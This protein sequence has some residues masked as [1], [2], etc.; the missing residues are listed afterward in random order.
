M[1]GSIFSLNA[2]PH[3]FL[4]SP[5]AAF[6]VIVSL[7]LNSLFVSLSNKEEEE[8]EKEEDFVLF[9][10]MKPP[11]TTDGHKGDDD[12]EDNEEDGRGR[13]KDDETI[14]C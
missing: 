2:P 11:T 4:G 3:N 9:P 1:S 7:P 6:V 14:V 5:E 13:G 10:A 12:F 8:E